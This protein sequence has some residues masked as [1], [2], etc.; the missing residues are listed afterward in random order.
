MLMRHFVL[1]LFTL[2]TLGANAQTSQETSKE[3]P[4]D[5]NSPVGTLT[6]GYFS[7]KE[8]LESMPE[9]ANV[10]K[11]M[12]DL[13]AKYEAEAKRAENEFNLKYEDFLEG[14]KDFPQTIL[15]KRQRE[16]QELMAKNIAFRNDSQ[17]LLAAAEQDAY[18]PLHDKLKKMLQ[19]IGEK[20]GFAF[21]LN[22]DNNA[23]PFINTANGKDI[24]QLVK[25]C[26]K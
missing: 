19:V 21:I 6:F 3:L 5:S 11:Q 14:Q 16:L 8:I 1:F 20:E 15:E 18:A 17:K 10:Q 25:D 26:M 4:I 22:T 13:K 24:T 7:Y 2:L 9:Y 23:C 12:A